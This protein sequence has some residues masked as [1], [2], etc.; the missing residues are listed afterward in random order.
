MKK[1]IKYFSSYFIFV[2]ISLLFSVPQI[3]AEFCPTEEVMLH[4]KYL[5]VCGYTQTSSFTLEKDTYITRIR[6]WYDASI[7]GDTLSATISGPD[8]YTK[9]SGE[10]NKEGCYGIW[11]AAMFYFNEVLKAGKYTVTANSKSVCYNPSGETT[12]ILYGCDAEIEQ[13][14]ETDDDLEG[15]AP[16]NGISVIDATTNPLSAPVYM[17]NI[18]NSGGSVGTL[19]GKMEL[20][21]DFPAYNKPVDI[22]ILIGLPDGRFYL[23]NEAGRFLNL[24]ES[25]FLTIAS[26]VAG[27]KTV[28]TIL[29]PFEIPSADSSASATPFDPFPENGEWT[30]YWLVA[31]ESSGDII[32]TIENGDYELGFYS[33]VI[34][35]KIDNTTYDLNITDYFPKSGP[36]GSYVLLKLDT[37]ITDLD[38]NITVFYDQTELVQNK[39]V[40]IAE[41]ILQIAVP[42][43]AQSGAIQIKSGNKLSNYVDFAVL[44]PVTTPLVSKS[45]SPSST[46]QTVNYN[47]EIVVTIPSGILDATRTLSI[48][49]VE[50]APINS[51]SPFS[52]GFAF[53]VSIDGLE[54][55]NDYIEIKV[56]YNPE[57]LNPDYTAEEQLIPMRWNEYENFWLPLAYKIDPINH[58]LSLYTNHLTL[59]EW[60]IIGSGAVATIPVTWA[61]EKLLN[62]VYVT[63][64]GN[65]RLLYSKSAVEADQTLND[66]SWVGITYKNPLY[67]IPIS[68]YS[69][70]HPKF[71]QDIGNLLETSLKNYVDVYKFKDPITTPGWIWG[72]SKNPITIKIDSWWVALG[73]DPNYEKVWENIHFPTD[74]L[75]DFNAYDSYVTIGHELFHRL[76]AEYYGIVGFKTPHNLWWMEAVAEYAG[77]RAAWSNRKFE[78]LHAKTGSDFLSYPISTTGKMDN[79]NGWNLD[80]SY[81]YAASAFI[82]FLVEKKGLNFKEMFEH[83]SNG[84]PLTAPLQKLNGYNGISLPQYY[85]DFASWSIFG[86]DSYLSKYSISTIAEENT[87]L[88]VPQ[89]ATAKI[90]FTGGNFSTISIYKFSEE[91][92]R[93][94]Y[95]P[96]PERLIGKEDSHEVKVNKG[97]VFYLIA[98][99]SGNEGETLY[100]NIQISV[101]G[102]E[103][104]T[105]SHTFNL[106]GGYS[107]KLWIIKSEIDNCYFKEDM[108][109]NSYNASVRVNFKDCGDRSGIQWDIPL[110]FQLGPNGTIIPDDYC[111]QGGNDYTQESL[112]GSWSCNSIN[113][114][115]T[116]A[117][118]SKIDPSFMSCWGPCVDIRAMFTGTATITAD[119]SGKLTSTGSGNV[120]QTYTYTKECCPTTTP[121]TKTCEKPFN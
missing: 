28:K 63:P 39:I 11:C 27:A 2:F 87:K 37:P 26:G 12:L 93:T 18:A 24:D 80:Q 44:S 59:I 21:V 68:S 76:Q 69:T 45:L 102:V 29:Q 25:G 30:V 65:F 62:D 42:N 7:G 96:T 67:P 1:H 91:Y 85:R 5:G 86:N 106:Q 57:L 58:T 66:K 97:D 119:S 104:L 56:K 22:W 95:I 118:N 50:N 55:L 98:D 48:S 61:G 108:F 32:K 38:S 72:E 105:T 20:S 90:S 46:E 99:N 34:K 115:F 111:S 16:P 31:P 110:C 53:D 70:L 100:T 47:D 10:I 19:S 60:V 94:S 3:Y 112:T 41:D 52:E 17:G 15:I 84:S 77:N 79:K 8:G 6:I 40:K 75:K 88:A 43:S 49:K 89:D 116:T 54:A 109:F 4:N 81:E 107:A 114:S 9:A 121:G 117:G 64:E 33:F 36:A 71:I 113:L 101:N 103:K 23:A 92:Q 13:P 51:I 82:Q 120:S 35:R 83:V 73:G 14:D 74:V 78:N